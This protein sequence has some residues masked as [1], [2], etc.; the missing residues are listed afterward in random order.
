M[1]QLGAA[2]RNEK[3]AWILL[4]E[5]YGRVWLVPVQCKRYGRTQDERSAEPCKLTQMFA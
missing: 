5:D 4:F 2:R 1:R 3:P